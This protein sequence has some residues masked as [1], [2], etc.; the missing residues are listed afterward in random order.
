MNK[1]EGNQMFSKYEDLSKKIEVFQQ[2]HPL[3]KTAEKKFKP[4]IQNADNK[5]DSNN[6]ELRM[7]VKSTDLESK[8]ESLGKVE[9]RQKLESNPINGDSIIEDSQN[10]DGAMNDSMDKDSP[11]KSYSIT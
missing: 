7:N 8:I 11:L 5:N 10:Y 2:I 6:D 3:P 9:S 4:F 1:N